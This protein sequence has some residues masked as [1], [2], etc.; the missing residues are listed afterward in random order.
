MKLIRDDKKV[1]VDAFLGTLSSLNLTLYKEMVER[2]LRL[3][4]GNTCFP[5]FFMLI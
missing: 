2:L 1:F 4:D 3:E 5:S